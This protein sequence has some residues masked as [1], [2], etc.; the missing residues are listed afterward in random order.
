M[1]K[2]YIERVY[3]D[4]DFRKLFEELINQKILNIKIKIK[5]DREARYNKIN[6]P[7]T[8]NEEVDKNE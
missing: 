1:T 3:G 8:N 5:N 7:S 6:Y 2:L 4:V